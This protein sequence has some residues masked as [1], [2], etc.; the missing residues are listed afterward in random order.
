METTPFSCPSNMSPWFC[1]NQVTISVVDEGDAYF[2]MCFLPK[3]GPAKAGSF[4]FNANYEQL[5]A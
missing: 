5:F 2:F 1:P 3:L 4:L